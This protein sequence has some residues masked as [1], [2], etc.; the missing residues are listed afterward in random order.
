MYLYLWLQL[1]RCS[2]QPPAAAQGQGQC[3]GGHMM[4]DASGWHEAKE[5][6]V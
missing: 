3:E 2:I 1:I 4:D 6:Y 5:L